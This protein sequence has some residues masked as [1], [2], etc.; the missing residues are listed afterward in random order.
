MIQMK[1]NP[2][3][4]IELDLTSKKFSREVIT[5]LPEV[6]KEGNSF[7]CLLGPDPQEGIFGCGD[8]PDEA[9][10]DWENSL[11]KRIEHPSEKDEVAQYVIDSLNT[12][13]KDVW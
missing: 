1:I 9:I 6:F 11:R 5:L 4:K 12:H 3:M 10:S 2:E 13:K 7:C 8:T